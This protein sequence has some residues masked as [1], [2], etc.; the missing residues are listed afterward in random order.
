MDIAF[1]AARTQSVT[2]RLRR[3]L[4]AGLLVSLFG[5][6]SA[7]QAADYTMTI[8]HL[9]PDDLKN[10]ETAPALKHFE[11]LVEAATDGAVDV[12][13][14]GNGALGGEVEVAQQ[15]RAGKTIQSVMLG[16]G[17]QASF[18]R[19]YEMI[20]APFLFPDYRTAW[21]FF[22]SAW[23]A[24]FMK[25]MIG[26]SGLR[27][28]GTL[29]DGGGF[30]AFANNKRLI[31]TVEDLKGMRIRVEENQAHMTIMTAL[32]ASPTTLPW[33]ELQTGLATGLVDGHFHAP[34][35]NDIFKLYDVTDYTTWSGHVYNT[36]TWSVSE[37]WF[38]DLP[39][40][41]Q[42][43]IVTSAR[44]AIAMAHGI[45]TQITVIGWA[46]SC[47]KFDECYVLPEAEKARMRDIAQPIYRDWL[48]EEFGPKAALFD[49]MRAE[50]DRIQQSQRR[51]SIER[52][53][54]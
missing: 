43:I 20:T 21:A 30:V 17:T 29:D 3:A 5:L 32:G 14:F 18:Y 53:L 40:E 31:K 36:I 52:Y 34:G 2:P 19:N 22:D 8:A 27:Y 42:E 23:F 7:T 9:Y 37:A 38:K 48:V 39:R 46:N 11:Q 13:V 6:V 54:D 26:E 33:G 49:E 15:A 1:D 45:A 44:E 51:A 10:N 35:V 12:E 16:S 50:I 47:E 25:P 41:Y 28:L 24:D 4:V